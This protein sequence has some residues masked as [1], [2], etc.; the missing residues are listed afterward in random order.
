[1]LS[2]IRINKVTWSRGVQLWAMHVPWILPCHKFLVFMKHSLIS[3]PWKVSIAE[4][5]G[6]SLLEFFFRPHSSKGLSW[7]CWHSGSLAYMA[8]TWALCASS[9]VYNGLHVLACAWNVFNFTFWTAR[10]GLSFFFLFPTKWLFKGLLECVLWSHLSWCL[11]CHGCMDRNAGH[12]I[13]RDGV[14]ELQGLK[15]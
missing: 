6:S 8:V 5:K 11:W 7:Q 2:V 1:M 3:E 13:G 4:K 10:P 12:G 15:A 14:A 9:L